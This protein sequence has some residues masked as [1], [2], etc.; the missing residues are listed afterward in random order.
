MPTAANSAAWNARPTFERCHRRDIELDGAPGGLGLAA[1]LVDF[2]ADGDDPSVEVDAPLVEVNVG[3]FESEDLVAAHAGHGGQPDDREEP[4][5]CC[6][7][8]QQ[9]QFLG[10]QRGAFD[11]LERALLGGSGQ[12]GDVAG[13][14]P[15]TLRIRE[16]SA[17]DEVDP[18]DRL[19]G[20]A[21]ALVGVPER[22][23]E[24]VELLVAQPADTDTPQ[25]RDDVQ[26]D[27]SLIV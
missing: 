12:K 17:D 3:P 22:F 18:V 27:V 1:G 10:G 15:P 8:H 7:A 9:T 16:R 19:G 4:V 26:M 24:R 13:H 2:V 6:G 5:P 23:V 14:Q 25:R 21:L 20:E 11:L